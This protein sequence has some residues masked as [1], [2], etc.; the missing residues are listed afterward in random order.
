LFYGVEPD[1]NSSIYRH[2]LGN[3]RPGDYRL[4]GEGTVVSPLGYAKQ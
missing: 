3:T 1:F 4:A 2:R